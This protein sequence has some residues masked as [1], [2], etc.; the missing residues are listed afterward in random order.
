[1]R[2]MRFAATL[3]EVVD[4]NKSKVQEMEKI[5]SRFVEV[6]TDLD[7]SSFKDPNKETLLQKWNKRNTKTNMKKF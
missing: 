1:M 4:F 3:M 2:K 6:I 5:V 7:E